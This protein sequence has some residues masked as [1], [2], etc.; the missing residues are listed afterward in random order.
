M[1]SQYQDFGV[2]NELNFVGIVFFKGSD[3]RTI[4]SVINRDL[5]SESIR[6]NECIRSDVKVSRK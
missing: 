1:L 2:R 4:L 6:N 3:Y 5:V